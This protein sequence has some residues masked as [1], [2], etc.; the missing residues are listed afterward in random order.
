MGEA[1][2]Q[3]GDGGGEVVERLVS[4]APALTEVQPGQVRNEAHQ[5]ARRRICKVQTGQSQLCNILET[6]HSGLTVSCSTN[7]TAEK[8]L[9]TSDNIYPSI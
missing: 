2:S 1:L 4:D 9:E 5:Q 7:H 8:P 6:P 3:G